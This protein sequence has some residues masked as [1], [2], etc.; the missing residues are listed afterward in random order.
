[1]IVVDVNV[2]LAAHV[3]AH[4]HHRA[5]HAWLVA[6]LSDPGDPVV[7]P[8]LVWVGFVRIATNPRVFTEPASLDQAAAFVRQVCQAPAYLPAPGLGDRIETF[9]DLCQLAETPSG[10]VTDAY[11]A[12]VARRHACPVAT[13]D[14]DFRRF[15]GLAIVTPAEP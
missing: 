8:D 1:M 4:T 9:L 3:Q 12:A 2:L 13:F 5:A 10:L 11:I 6:A 14:R 7:V 15:D